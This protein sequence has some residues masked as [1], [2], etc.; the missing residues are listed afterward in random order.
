[1]VVRSDGGMCGKCIASLRAVVRIPDR[2]TEKNPT[3]QGKVKLSVLIMMLFNI[4]HA[5]MTCI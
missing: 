1:M 5:W 2:V 4:S 3:S